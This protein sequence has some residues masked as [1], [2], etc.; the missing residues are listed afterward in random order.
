MIIPNTQ[1]FS[2]GKAGGVPV[3][4]SWHTAKLRAALSDDERLDSKYKL[5][6][7]AARLL[8]G[9]RVAYCMRTITPGRGGVEVIHTPGRGASYRGLMT[10]GSVWACPICASRITEHRKAELQA[11]LDNWS[12][13]A[14][15][16]AFTLQHD[17][18]D[19]LKEL[20]NHLKAAFQALSRDRQVKNLKAQYGII[21]TVSSLEVTHGASGWHPHRHVLY[22]SE[23]KLSTDEINALQ[24]GIS[25]R[26]RLILKRRGRYGG[27]SCAVVFTTTGTNQAAAAYVAKGAW[28][29][30]AELAKAP[31]KSG[32]AGNRSPFQLLDASDED[33]Q[34]AALFREYFFAFRRSHQLQYSRGLR[35]LLGMEPELTDEELAAVED[36]GVVMM[37]IAPAV[38]HSI[39][40]RELRAQVLIKARSGDVEALQAWMDEQGLS[41]GYQ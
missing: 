23:R 27:E 7:K 28:G 36:E 10:C 41:P 25:E 11:A 40:R 31:V 17:Q 39:C 33:T 29:A 38:W 9:E 32:H 14:V 20:L 19:T 6:A 3:S 37:S 22:L 18:N 16:A 4:S 15:M 34:A 13:Y 2:I 26:W 12:G 24:G 5:Q 35:A 21:G 8:P 1:T 30:A